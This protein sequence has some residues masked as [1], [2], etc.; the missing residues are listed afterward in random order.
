MALQSTHLCLIGPDAIPWSVVNAALIVH[1][2]TRMYTHASP[3]SRSPPCQK[4]FHKELL[5]PSL[6]RAKLLSQST[7]TLAYASSPSPPPPLNTATRFSLVL[8]VVMS[9]SMHLCSLK[10]AQGGLRLPREASISLIAGLWPPYRNT[11]VAGE[12]P[13][14]ASTMHTLLV[15]GRRM[16]SKLFVCPH[17]CFYRAC[18]ETY[19]LLRASTPACTKQSR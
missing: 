12:K 17:F 15:Y 1:N 6:I 4:H 2:H 13:G 7:L 11:A 16:G 8:N 3:F 14:L 10:G 18:K 19:M 9:A 5:Y